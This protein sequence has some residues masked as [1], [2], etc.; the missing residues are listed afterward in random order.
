SADVRVSRDSDAVVVPSGAGRPERSANPERPARIY[1]LDG[2]RFVAAIGVML[3]H[4]TARWSLAWGT[5]PV[6]RF[7]VVGHI[8]TYFAL[9]PEMFFVISGFVILW[10]AWGR[11]VPKVVA[12]R[13]ARLYPSYWAALAPTSVLL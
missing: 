2:L 12:S 8:T 5:E 11:T 1:T 3:Y 4:F 13:V 10:T 7:P 9:A 6:E